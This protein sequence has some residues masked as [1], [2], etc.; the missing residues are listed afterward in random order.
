MWTVSLP[1]MVK[2]RRLSFIAERLNTP[3]AGWYNAQALI[4]LNYLIG[5]PDWKGGLVK[6]AGGLD[7]IGSKPNKPYDM[8]KLH[9]GN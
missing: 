6:P 3:M 9:P 4:S 1:P 7:Y 8:S 5:N 2:K